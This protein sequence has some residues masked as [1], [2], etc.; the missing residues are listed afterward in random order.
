MELS[1]ILTLTGLGYFMNTNKKRTTKN[2]RNPKNIFESERSLKVLQGE[3]N[4]ASNVMKE[5][6]VVLPGPPRMDKDTFFNKVDYHNKKLPI[7][8]T[9]V[10]ANADNLYDDQVPLTKVR[11]TQTPP[12]VPYSSNYTSSGG[13]HGISLTGEPMHPNSYFHNNMVPFFGS[14]VT[15]TLDEKAYSTTLENFTGNNVE[16]YQEKTEIGPMFK[17]QPNMTNPYGMSSYTS[18]EQNRYIPSKIM[19]NIGPVEQVHVGPGLNQGYTAE[20]SGGFQQANTRDY[21][22]PK[23]VDELRVKTNPKLSYYGRVLTGQKGFKP[24]KIGSVEKRHPDSFYINSPERYFTTVGERTEATLRP[25]IV[26]RPTHRRRTGIYTYHG[27]AK[28]ASGERHPV[29]SKY[30]KSCKSIYSY[31]YRNLGSEGTWSGA[32]EGSSEF[33]YGKQ[34]IQLRSTE[35]KDCTAEDGHLGQAHT[36]AI[37]HG[38]IHNDQEARPTLKSLTEDNDHMGNMT[39]RED[40]GYVHDPEDVA[41][42]TMK[43]TSEVNEHMGNVAT[44]ED[45]GY[46]KDPEDVAK[47]TMKELTEENVHN[48]NIGMVAGGRGKIHNQKLRNTVRQFLTKGYTGG[49]GA[50]GAEKAPS[51]GA[52][53]NSITKSIRS[54]LDKGY[55]PNAGSSKDYGGRDSAFTSKGTDEIKNKYLR[56]RGMN[57]DRIY[58]SLPRNIP[59]AITK[60][61]SRLPNEPIQDRLDF[62]IYKNIFK[63]NPYFH[64]FASYFGH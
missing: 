44:G 17:V 47:T 24:G 5:E 60:P 16:N 42:S 14:K 50:V 52:V 46:V 9:E 35:K 22:L 30:R 43:E 12:R 10:P 40:R 8:F 25:N 38:M 53:L 29:R 20:P 11:E 7:E 59:S 21:T 57:V 41:R 26:M 1:T 37:T 34:N 63:N 54:F 19:N 39:T 4:L 6:N 32:G 51:R 56:E 23:T 28:L 33:D 64:S 31:G 36:G 2:L 62:S 49:A 18:F 13:W 48:G 55:T 58:N 15:Q 45:R 61:N 3:F 27:P